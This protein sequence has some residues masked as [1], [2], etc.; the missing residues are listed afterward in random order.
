[1]GGV[2][3][4]GQPPVLTRGWMRASP[5]RSLA[6][7]PPVGHG[8]LDDR[9]DAQRSGWRRGSLDASKNA[10]LDAD[11]RSP[12]PGRPTISRARNSA[13]QQVPCGD[14]SVACGRRAGGLHNAVE[15]NP[16]TRGK[17][18]LEFRGCSSHATRVRSSRNTPI[19][20]RDR[21][22]FWANRGV[23]EPSASNCACPVAMKSRL[24]RSLRVGVAPIPT[25]RAKC[26]GPKHYRK[27]AA[28]PTKVAAHGESVQSRCRRPRRVTTKG[29]AYG[30]A[31]RLVA[32]AS[33]L[34][35]RSDR[36]ACG[37][38]GCVAPD[39][40]MDV[41]RRSSAAAFWH[42]RCSTCVMWSMPPAMRAASPPPSPRSGAPSPKPPSWHPARCSSPSCSPS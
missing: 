4:Q 32:R 17:L 26:H 21:P 18:S 41:R 5:R 1:M 9:V 40:C 10:A 31:R 39:A 27:G 22:L 2:R 34:Q 7:V 25:R 29:W 38:G 8:P 12:E 20:K 42:W 14:L 13:S 11:S 37:D 28:H 35:L 36:C 16:I 24:H 19:R 23:A 6:E 15:L 30:P 3:S 33:R